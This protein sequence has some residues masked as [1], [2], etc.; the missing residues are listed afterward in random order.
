MICRLAAFIVGLVVM[1]SAL[2][3]TSPAAA[4][5]GMGEHAAYAHAHHAKTHGNSSAGHRLPATAPHAD[6]PSGDAA[7]CP[8]TPENDGQHC[9]PCYVSGDGILSGASLRQ[10]FAKKPIAP[11]LLAVVMAGK[12]QVLNYVPHPIRLRRIRFQPG[13][14]YEDVLLVTGRLRI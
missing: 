1:A 7:P 10:S 14:V 12:R 8:V 2:P 9:P 11:E 5:T 13:P 4:A 6:Q 3:L